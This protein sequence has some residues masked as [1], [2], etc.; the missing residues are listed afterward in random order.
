MDDVLPLN[1]LRTFEA[2]ARHLSFTRAAADLNV[3]QPSVSRRISELEALL[4]VALFERTKPRLRLTE[5]GRRLQAAVSAGF[6]RIRETVDD[7]RHAAQ[8]ARAVINTAIGFAT[9]WLL[10]RL[11]EFRVRYPDIGLEL[12]T[13]DGNLGFDTGAC[14]V[15][16]TFGAP[17]RLGA[18]E[19]LV[20]REELF[21]IC[22]PG[23]G[24]APDMD[25]AA[26]AQGRLLFLDDPDHTGD[27]ARLFEGSGVE[28]P[29]AR[30]GALFNSFVVYLQAV[31]TGAG[32]GLGWGRLMDG[33]IADGRLRRIGGLSRVTERGY[34]CVHT[35][36][37]RSR[38]SAQAF[39]DW[40]V[41]NAA[42][43]AT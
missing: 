20:F 18:G 41:D 29:A 8:P 23:Y 14:D 38:D 33:M 21:P 37:V 1:A 36:R 15:V 25:A 43:D 34:F 17:G 4:G 40:L 39:C 22:A 32:I 9:L 24:A 6:G 31:A 13:R 10:P 42:S 3:L 30:S 35:G 19:R 5:E 11:A 28:P 26:L 2:A 16:V 27:W 12:V 7:L